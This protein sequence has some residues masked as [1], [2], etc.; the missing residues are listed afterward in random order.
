MKKTFIILLS[1]L[2]M[3]SGVGFGSVQHHCLSKQTADILCESA[4]CSTPHSVTAGQKTNQ[5]ETDSCCSSPVTTLPETNV[6]THLDDTCCKIG[7]KYTQLESSFLPLIYG[8]S[9]A[10]NT[11]VEPFYHIQQYPNFG[12]FVVTN[13]T[14]PSIH[15]NI[16]LL[17]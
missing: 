5:P 7:H 8:T 15:V 6:E 4:C 9:Q 3:I 12:G 13:F 17:I 14:D 10:A 11:T 1:L 2:F 16:P